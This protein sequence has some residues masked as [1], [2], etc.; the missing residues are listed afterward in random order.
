MPIRTRE[1]ELEDESRKAFSAV[2]PSGWT[3]S[4]V[5]ND[6]GLDGVV[7]L[8]DKGQTTGHLFWVQL[9]ATDEVNQNKALKLRVSLEHCHYYRSLEM[10]VLIVRYLAS[11]CRLFVKWFCKVSFRHARASAK[12]VGLSLAAADEWTARTL[13]EIRVDLELLRVLKEGMPRA[14]K[15][16]LAAPDLDPQARYGA[17]NSIRR[18]TSQSNLTPTLVD[19][20][21]S[22]ALV[23]IFIGDGSIT[24]WVT[25]RRS[26]RIPIRQSHLDPTTGG[27]AIAADVLTMAGLLIGFWHRLPGG[28]LI[29]SNVL[30]SSFV[31]PSLMC[32]NLAIS[33]ASVGRSDDAVKLLTRLVE[34]HC[35]EASYWVITAFLIAGLDGPE[36]MEPALALVRSIGARIEHSLGSKFAS[37]LEYSVGNRIRAEHPELALECYLLAAQL[38]PSYKERAYWHSELGG[39]LFLLGEFV[40]AARAYLQA[41]VIQEEPADFGKCADAL[42]FAGFYDDAKGFFLRAGPIPE[43]RLK[44]L[45]LDMIAAEGFPSTQRRHLDAE[46]RWPALKGDEQARVGIIRKCM[47]QDALSPRAW[48][49]L[50][51]HTAGRPPNH[52]ADCLT[53]A[54]VSSMYDPVL[55]CRALVVTIDALGL[56]SER[57]ADLIA[58]ACFLN[59]SAMLDTALAM[60][61]DGVPMDDEVL[62]R[63][64]EELAGLDGPDEAPILIRQVHEDGTYTEMG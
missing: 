21:A 19:G 61:R 35:V 7:E 48:V 43:W 6:Y 53:A 55:W 59:R 17:L 33:L 63:L 41:Q 29:A 58:C 20:D 50:S 11:S 44:V 30:D 64:S 13:E 34:L 54:A 42:L 10:P 56:D 32:S 51:E 16:S 18:R 4:R 8:F 31:S 12:T 23:R 14:F 36:A 40:A 2:L 60:K 49:W 52:Q 22:D 26:F 9:K 39:I 38:D 3:F 25:I 27:E 57:T 24:V 62:R 46:Y 5:D 37:T 47:A 45:L 15:L 1:H 28:E